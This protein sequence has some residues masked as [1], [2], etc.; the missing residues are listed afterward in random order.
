MMSPRLTPPC[1]PSRPLTANERNRR[2]RW[3]EQHDM[4]HV[5]GLDVS[6]QAVAAL[7]E[8]G[9]LEE[10]LSEDRQAVRA[11]AERY[12]NETLLARASGR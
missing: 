5:R 6:I 4:T 8:L 11:A 12:M 3:R 7:V 1:A 2:R 9:Y 10:R